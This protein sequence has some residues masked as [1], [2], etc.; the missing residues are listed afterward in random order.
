MSERRGS[1]SRRKSL[2]DIMQEVAEAEQSEDLSRS[3]HENVID[4]GNMSDDF[5]HMDE[6]V[7]EGDDDELDEEALD[8]VPST[9]GTIFEEL[10]D[11]E[12][13]ENSLGPPVSALDPLYETQEMGTVYEESNE[14]E[15]AE[16]STEQ[17]GK[18]DPRYYYENYDDSQSNVSAENPP[19]GYAKRRN[20]SFMAT[21]RSGRSNDSGGDRSVSSLPGV[22]GSETGSADD[23]NLNLNA[24]R[25]SGS[26][27]PA[28]RQFSQRRSNFYRQSVVGKESNDSNIMDGSVG[29]NSTSNSKRMASSTLGKLSVRFGGKSVRRSSNRSSL[30]GENSSNSGTGSMDISTA[31]DKLGSSGDDWN[32]TIAAAA[33]VAATTNGPTTRNTTQYGTGEHV[34]VFL[35]LL[36]HQNRIDDRNDFT[37]SPVNEHGFPAGAGKSESQ[38]Q[39]P[40]EFLICTVTTVHF[41]EDERYYTVR[42]GDTGAEQRADPSVMAP[43]RD[44]VGIEMAFRAA[45]RTR[46]AEAEMTVREVEEVGRVQRCLQIFTQWPVSFYKKRMIPLYQRARSRT[47]VVAT[48][49]L[50]G[51]TG[52]SFKLRLTGIN[53]L[54]LCSFV[55]LFNDV[56]ALSFVSPNFDFG[57]TII[58]LC[59]WIVLVLELF[60]EAMIRPKNYGE[61]RS[62]DKAFSPSTAR[63][64]NA[65]H[66]CFEAAA[67]LLFLPHFPCLFDHERCGDDI[68]FSGIY[69][70]INSLT[71]TQ[72]YE[73]AFGRLILGLTFLRVFG[74]VRHWK[75]MWLNN[76]FEKDAS[77]SRIVR[78]ML[79]MGA[80]NS[81]RRRLSLRKARKKKDDEEFD[82]GELNEEDEID[83]KTNNVEDQ[84]LKNAAN[85]GTALM[86]VN[87][88]R[89]LVLLL[90]IVVVFPAIYAFRRANEVDTELVGLLQAN[91]LDANTTDQ[92]EYLHSAVGAWLSAVS[93]NYAK[94][95]YLIE[96]DSTEVSVVWAQLLPVR[97][98]W[99]RDDGVITDCESFP[100][101]NDYACR[102]W[103][104][105]PGPDIATRE[106]FAEELNIRVGALQEYSSNALADFGTSGNLTEF[107]V[108]SINDLSESVAAT[109]RSL[110]LLEVSMLLLIM[111]GL[112]VMRGDAG[113]LVLEP[114][115]RM[116][117]TVVR[118][119]ENPLSQ[120]LTSNKKSF[121]P[122]DSISK[123]S[124]A[125]QLGN[126]ETEQLIN[127]IAKIADLL[128]KCW[129]VAGA[130]IISS[131]LARTKDGKTVVFNPTV[132]GKRVYAL[133]G[134]VAVHEFDVLLRALESQVMVLINDV[135]RVVHDEVYRWSL[136]DSGQCNKNLGAA[137]LMVFRIGDFS[138]VHDRKK[139]ATDVVFNSTMKARQTKAKKRRGSGRGTGLPSGSKRRPT[140]TKFELGTNGTLQL[141]S[142]PGIQSFAD[143]ALLGLL[144][145]YAGV[146]RDDNLLGWKKDFRLGA[147]VGAFSVQI[148][149]GMDAGWAVEGAVGSEY[150]IDATYLS[151]HVNMASR[152]MSATKQYGVTI[153]LSQAVE[154]LL[155]K[156]ARSQLR[157]LDTVFVKG[158]RVA[159]RIFT[160]DARSE[161]ADFFLYDRPADQAD[162]DAE[163]YSVNIWETDQDL[164]AMR[165]HVSEKFMSLFRKGV[166]MYLSGEWTTAIELLKEADNNMIE[167]VIEEGF[168]EADVSE[169]GDRVFDP[170]SKDEE[171]LAIR[172]KYGDGA[173]KNLVKYME[174]RKA[175][176]PP[177]WEGVRALMSK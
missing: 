152:M 54:V 44:V 145:S 129:G 60:F 148:I 144:K 140:L 71:S 91:N 118:Y 87:S 59:V 18:D 92:C 151:P 88:H 37:I 123:Q 30:S 165:Q 104:D 72:G 173:C 96:A 95:R 15:S 86:I 126:Y 73:Q 155:S 108:E 120:S 142:L 115:Q 106:Y 43:I 131:N 143:R 11:Q 158:S 12:D 113:R 124:E 164:I 133:F 75:Q 111:F 5:E 141:S 9:Q 13:S 150:K 80:D 167:S 169:Y 116:L 68:F 89:V 177:D 117:K 90:A 166:D 55:Y 128:R 26:A 17:Y 61:L 84:D 154:E 39:G 147:G 34:L 8:I 58:G 49:L 136:G 62:S 2:L 27:I 112:T 107:R 94:Q 20:G 176:P 46:N 134:F 93:V 65:F 41:D 21:R 170:L 162:V 97:C 119:A 101:Q 10:E 45:K 35:N 138:E 109:F 29:S 42:R 149:Y 67:L 85:V 56:F 121:S 82:D 57:S 110:F 83:G 64:I 114:L 19:P 130:G 103:E 38:K 159:Q 63:H 52:Y 76:T 48:H 132:P 50:H 4:D 174:R 127:A 168:I 74:L 105:A 137:F 102:V 6:N 24:R 98:S 135:A 69:G 33:F 78:N 16:Q 172:N 81:R 32:S 160:Y 47:K 51:D 25:S 99:Q 100:I 153:L 157:H 171:I 125:E 3:F 28:G 139:R 70:A 161:G 53:F 146:H 156:P 36:N 122:D 163:A 175:K 23:G 31:V 1:S 22:L 7:F 40:F 66:L 79:M 14:N 77:N